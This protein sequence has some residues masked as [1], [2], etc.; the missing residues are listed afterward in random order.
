MKQGT[1]DQSL[2]WIGDT[3]TVQVLHVPY[4]RG[5]TGIPP[6][7]CQYCHEILIEVD[8][9]SLATPTTNSYHLYSLHKPVNSSFSSSYI[10]VISVIII[11]KCTQ[12]LEKL[13]S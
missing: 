7:I 2:L 13:F 3:G 8:Y 12:W 10:I 1:Q 6:V 4:K 9:I 11:A 5:G